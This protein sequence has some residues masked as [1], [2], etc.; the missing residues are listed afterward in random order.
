LKLN[1]YNHVTYLTIPEAIT[2]MLSDLR[3]GLG[4]S[5][6]YFHHCCDKTIMLLSYNW[7]KRSHLD[8]VL[9]NLDGRA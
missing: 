7:E 2:Y 3:E 1:Q 9:S 8:M 5:Q 4:K 6:I